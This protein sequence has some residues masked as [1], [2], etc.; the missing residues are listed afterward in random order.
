MWLFFTFEVLHEVCLVPSCT[1][2]QKSMEILIAGRD[3]KWSLQAYRFVCKSGTRRLRWFIIIISLLILHLF[4]CTIFG[5]P[6]NY[7]IGYIWVNNNISLPWI[8]AIWG[9]FPLLTM[10][11]GFGRRVWSWWNL[12]RYGFA[13]KY[14]VYSQTNSHLKTGLWSAKPLGNWGTQHFQ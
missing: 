14:W 5:H 7:I 6:R 8:K 10:I 2:P 1:W 13:W 12:P 4:V 11:P 9:W 3:G